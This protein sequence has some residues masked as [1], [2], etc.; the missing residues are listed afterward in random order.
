VTR[1]FLSCVGLIKIIDLHTDLL[2]E[3]FC[4]TP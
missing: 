1:G 2:V 3:Q 4:I